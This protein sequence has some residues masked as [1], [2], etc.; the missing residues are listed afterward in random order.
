MKITLPTE[1]TIEINLYADDISD[2]VKHV[3]ELFPQGDR[4]PDEF[5]YRDYNYADCNK[6]KVTVTIIEA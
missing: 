6:Y 4:F 5:N 2:A 1:A 3:A